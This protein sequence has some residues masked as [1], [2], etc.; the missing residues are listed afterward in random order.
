MNDLQ[1]MNISG[2]DC[3]E[4]DGTAYLKLETVAR[5]LG[6][7]REKNGVEYVMWD[8]VNKYLSEIGFPHKCGNVPVSEIGFSQE[9]AKTDFI[10]ENIFYRLAMKAKNETAER[11]QALVADEIIPSIRK[12]GGYIANQENLT[13]EQIVANAL[14]VAQNIISQKDKQIE[15]MKPKAEFFDAVADSRTAISMNEVSKVLG[16]KGYGRNNLF[17]FLRNNGILD[18]WNVPYQRYIDCGWF[19]VIEQKYTRQGEPCV[20]TKT[21]VYQKGVDAIRKK[22]LS[23]DKTV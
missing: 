14:I 22:I 20:T 1:I 3:Y 13:P 11:F 6:F 17:E 9:V 5:G 16:I 15:Q 12:N 2:V 10:P 21:L 19:R 18:R 7:T 4:K 23:V 8:R